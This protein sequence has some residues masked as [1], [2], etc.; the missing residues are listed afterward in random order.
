MIRV[1]RAVVG[2][3]SV[4]VALLVVAC[5]SSTTTTEGRPQ[6]ECA[7]TVWHRALSDAARVEIVADWDGWARPGRVLEPLRGDGWRVTSFQPPPGEHTYAIVEDGA[8]L[9]DRN[10]STTAFHD[11]VEVTWVRVPDCATPVLEVTAARGSSG[12][13]ATV[14]GMFLTSRAGDPVDPASVTV[15]TPG[16]SAITP[17]AVD[18]D[19]VTGAIEVTLDGLA[20]GK[21]ALLLHARDARGREADPVRATTWIEPEPFDWRDAIVYQVMVDRFRDGRGA[22]A[23]PELASG[24]AGGNVDG[25]RAAVESGQLAAL[26]VN[27]LWLSPLYANPEGTFPGTDGHAYSSY[28]GY[29][30]IASRALD[31]HVATEASLD[32]LIAAAHARGMRVLFDVVPNHVHQEHPYVTAHA[33]DGWFDAPDGRCVCG[34]TCD[35]ATHIE[36]CWFAPYL[37][38][39]N[40]RNP[41]VATQITDDV[42]WWMERFDGDGLRIDAVPM[43]PRAASRRIAQAVRA[44][45]DHPGNRTFLLGENFTGPYGFELLQYEL[46]PG[47]LD[48]EFHFPLMWSLRAA[49]AE[50]VAPLSAIDAT[51]HRG[52]V[53]WAGSGAVM[54]TMIGN[55]DVARF[56]S[57][58]A[59]DVGGDPWT[60]AAVPAVVSTVYARQIMALGAVLTLPGAPVVY[61]GDELAMVGHADPD[62][63]RVMP[64][65]AS[66][67]PAQRTT[68]DAIQALGR[69]RAC[70]P[71]LRRGT[72]RT[73]FTDAEHLVFARELPGA[74]TAVVVL[75]RSDTEPL[76]VALPGVPAGDYVDAI[77]GR[78]TSL[79]PEL[80]HLPAGP[81]TLQ[82]LLPKGSACEKR[83]LR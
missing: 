78:T 19:P 34:Q 47:G 2:A 11:G 35:W 64:A 12:G 68:R 26:G 55:H 27:T 48:S 41:A 39:L 50:G 36:E 21:H 66:L 69:A 63:R 44:R 15:T 52:E 20:P 1:R 51:W 18:V 33:K 43:M 81:M 10:V 82:L 79:R 16:G 74:D 61:Y 75:T 3:C 53:S 65:E 6:R 29:W 56:A 4:V 54:S 23:Q 30:P 49:I 13:A 14:K 28:H 73:L 71:A 25:V 9:T 32:A 46:G 17:S 42:A 83:A 62:S 24:R 59:G 45:F 57:D 60:P 37:P 40:W 67:T 8:W 70:A 38:D 31:P 22:L 5:R 76:T 72:Y 80:T 7:V 58:S 77:Q